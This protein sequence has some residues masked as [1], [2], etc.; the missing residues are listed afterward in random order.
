MKK[1]KIIEIVATTI[2]VV[3]LFVTIFFVVPNVIHLFVIASQAPIENGTLHR[4]LTQYIS[5][6]S[7]EPIGRTAVWD[8]EL[9]EFIKKDLD[10]ALENGYDIKYTFED[11]T[12]SIYFEDGEPHLFLGESTS[13]DVNNFSIYKK[14]E[15]KLVIYGYDGHG[16]DL[17]E[18]A[19]INGEG[20][21]YF[22]MI[23]FNKNLPINEAESDYF[24]SSGFVPLQDYGCLVINTEKNGEDTFCCFTLYKDTNI[25]YKKVF[26]K[27]IK[28]VIKYTGFLLTTDGEV[29]L[30]YV[31]ISNP[32]KLDLHFEKVATGVDEIERRIYLR[33]KSNELP[34]IKKD[35]TYYMVY[36]ENYETFLYYSFY[37]SPLSEKV[38]KINYKTRLIALKD[39][40]SYAEFKYDFS[41]AR[42]LW[43]ADIYI[44]VDQNIFSFNY[45]L[46]GYDKDIELYEP[47]I[48]KYEK[49]VYSIEEFWE[50][51]E[52]IRNKYAEKY[53]YPQKN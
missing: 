36:P 9:P 5:K 43:Q 14:D 39:A 18:K 30:P 42:E 24:Y 3:T 21:E 10:E 37:Y 26:E 52:A 33:S 47:E 50:N 1:E 35:N 17:F 45:T 16:N 11:S 19:I 46:N 44:K 34:V 6:F 2:C 40:F 4:D 8:S 31:D 12:I 25:I 32:D 51:I 27:P 38:S 22:K 53:D 41:V 28:D 13:F 48:E 20:H 49:N 29:Y 7:D 15:S 23:N